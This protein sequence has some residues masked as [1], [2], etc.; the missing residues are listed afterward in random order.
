MKVQARLNNYRKSARK[1]REV[2]PVI[3]GLD[4]IEAEW[5]L[6][7]LKKGCA[8]DLKKLLLSAVSNA[9]NNHGLDKDNLFVL[10]MVAQE[11]RTLKRWRPRAHG[12][13]APILKRSCHVI[14]TIEEREE[15]KGRKKV[16][17]IVE[18]SEEKKGKQAEYKSAKSEEET[19]GKEDQGE[20]KEEQTKAK[21]KP[22]M[23]ASKKS[24]GAVTK[25]IFRRKSF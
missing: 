6:E 8:Q 18:K 3:N 13:A 25:K 21:D 7:H 1:M 10:E 11:G 20:M 14:L 9:Q 5:Q 22:G 15:G 4:V 19:E 12:R 2:A 23:K 17:R 24:K 16:E